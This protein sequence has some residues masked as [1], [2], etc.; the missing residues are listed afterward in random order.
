MQL[1]ASLPKPML[2]LQGHASSQDLFQGNPTLHNLE[3]KAV[4]FPALA[5][6]GS[7]FVLRTPVLLTS[8]KW[9]PLQYLLR[10]V[11]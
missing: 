5:S 11:A 10:A 4:N 2:A 8:Q 7:T 6:Q 9:K 3:A 1:K